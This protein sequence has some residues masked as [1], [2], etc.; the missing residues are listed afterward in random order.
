MNSKKAYIVGENTHKSLSPLIFNYWFAK[1]KIKAEYKYKEIKPKNFDSSVSKIL[2]EDGLCGLNITN[3]FKEK[4]IPYLHKIDRISKKIGAVNCVS[5]S[6]SAFYGTNTDWIGYG[7]A[8]KEKTLKKTNKNK[9]VIVI[10]FGGAAKAVLFS[11]NRLGYQKIHIFNRTPEKIKNLQ[12][13]KFSPHPLEDIYSHIN[14]ADIIINTT[15]INVLHK[16][17]NERINHK[18]IASDIVYRP[19]ETDFLKLFAKS[20]DKIYGISMLLY[21]AAPCFELWFGIKPTID[22]ELLRLVKSEII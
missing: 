12:N 11:L 22:E 14:S 19:M 15:P 9:K 10:G 18:T 20:K 6:K 8:L 16:L 21:Q 1:Y 4:I 3:P 2:S 7:K 5:I 17:D 13:K